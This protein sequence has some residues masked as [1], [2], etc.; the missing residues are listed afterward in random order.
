[1]QQDDHRAANYRWQFMW[2]V[3]QWSSGVVDA[4]CS[5]AVT[6]TRR[7]AASACRRGIQCMQA[8]GRVH[9]GGAS[10]AC[11]VGPVHAGGACK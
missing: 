2:E 7:G 4:L 8:G 5:H 10:S 3:E 9:A 1:M 11:R 6:T